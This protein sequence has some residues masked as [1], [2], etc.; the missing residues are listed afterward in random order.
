MSGFDKPKRLQSLLDQ[1]PEMLPWVPVYPS[2]QIPL[3]TCQCLHYCMP[4]SSKD[5]V[6]LCVRAATDETM[7]KMIE[8]VYR[9]LELAHPNAE[10]NEYRDPDNYQEKL[11]DYYEWIMEIHFDP[12]VGRS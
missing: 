8:G 12:S 2:D 11:D 3:G 4:Q 7:E 1:L 6:R 10:T 9:A 5:S